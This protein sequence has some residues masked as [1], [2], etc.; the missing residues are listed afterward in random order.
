MTAS[1]PAGAVLDA[2]GNLSAASTSIDAVVSYDVASPT[3]TIDQAAGQADPAGTVPIHFTVV[4][5]EPVS[6]FEA[7]Q[8]LLGG[9][10]PGTLIVTVWPV[11]AATY[12]VAVSGLTGNGIVTAAVAAGAVV[13]AAGNP[14]QASTSQDDTVMFWGNPWQNYPLVYDAANDYMVTPLDVLV[15]INCINAYGAGPLPRTP[16]VPGANPIYVDIDGNREFTSLDALPVINYLD[17]LSPPSGEGES[18]RNGSAATWGDSQPA[19]QTDTGDLRVAEPGLVVGECGCP[20]APPALLSF[21]PFTAPD[22]GGRPSGGSGWVPATPVAA[23]QA[24]VHRSA[25]GPA[26]RKASPSDLASE[27]LTDLDDVLSDIASDVARG[28]DRG[29]ER[30]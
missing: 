17:R 18:A 22:G 24:R 23:E 4:F 25:T 7:A 16:A 20:V 5:S 15:I 10:A 2:A 8:V 1:V 21:A 14:S 13:D 29:R 11:D 26:L 9:T 28:W 27:V 3:V 12:D 6:G 30:A 19:W